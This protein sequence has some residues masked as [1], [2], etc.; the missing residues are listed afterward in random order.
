MR[1]PND[2]IS[3]LAASKRTEKA[4]SSPISTLEGSPDAQV[5]VEPRWQVRQVG[6]A[7]IE[8]RFEEMLQIL[9]F[10]QNNIFTIPNT[11]GQD[12]DKIYES[13]WL[14]ASTEPQFKEILY[15]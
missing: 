13:D 3:Y 11:K 4:N 12:S 8:L 9:R 10:L 2:K 1:T 14:L 6:A 15:I 5:Q 7:S